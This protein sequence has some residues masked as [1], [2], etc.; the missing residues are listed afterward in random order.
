MANVN[1][2]ESA[3]NRLE[4]GTIW[5]R[6]LEIIATPASLQ[7]TPAWKMMEIL[8]VEIQELL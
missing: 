1:I 2:M 6:R 3:K 8:N 7:P 5:G 4:I